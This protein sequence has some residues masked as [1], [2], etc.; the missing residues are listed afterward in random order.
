MYANRCSQQ[1]ASLLLLHSFFCA[2]GLAGKKVRKRLLFL[3]MYKEENAAQLA[4]RSRMAAYKRAGRWCGQARSSLKVQ[5]Q[6][7]TGNG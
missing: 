7:G 1:K 4:R 5:P 2:R 6:I 3:L